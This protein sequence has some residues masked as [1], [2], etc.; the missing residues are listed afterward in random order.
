MNAGL[1]CAP[2]AELKHG[3]KYGDHY[4]PHDNGVQQWQVSSPTEI[5]LLWAPIVCAKPSDHW[6]PGNRLK[7]PVIDARKKRVM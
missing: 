1:I 6:P 4:F 5:Y 7:S 3:W 2:A